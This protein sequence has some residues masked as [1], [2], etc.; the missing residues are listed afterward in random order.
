MNLKNRKV[1]LLFYKKIRYEKS[2][3]NT[4]VLIV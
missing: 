1:F 3:R 2:A 4:R